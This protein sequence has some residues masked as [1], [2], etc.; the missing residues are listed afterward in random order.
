MAAKHW[1]DITAKPAW[2]A[3]PLGTVTSI[4]PSAF[5]GGDGS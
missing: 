5:D 4:E 3:R 2:V 1:E